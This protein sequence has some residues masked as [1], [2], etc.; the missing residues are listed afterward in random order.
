MRKLYQNF[1]LL[2]LCKFITFEITYN[3]KR[4]LL[5]IL[6]QNTFCIYNNLKL[7]DNKTN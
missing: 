3:K 1:F 7:M 5:Q 2:I 6:L 4:F